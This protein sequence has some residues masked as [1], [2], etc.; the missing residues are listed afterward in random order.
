MLLDVCHTFCQ[1]IKILLYSHHYRGT[2]AYI[3]DPCIR[4]FWFLKQL[5]TFQLLWYHQG[6]PQFLIK[7]DWL[8]YILELC[9][10]FNLF[11]NSLPEYLNLEKVDQIKLLH[12]NMPIYVQLVLSLYFNEESGIEQVNNLPGINVVSH[13]AFKRVDVLKLN[14][15]LGLFHPNSGLERYKNLISSSSLKVCKD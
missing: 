7:E 11:A 14:R 13:A 6:H 4:E 15:H 9:K 3:L 12:Q 5:K 2:R 8:N 10:Q 1:I